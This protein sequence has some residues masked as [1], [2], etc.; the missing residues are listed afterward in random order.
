MD[1]TE[2]IEFIKKN[3]DKD[4][5]LINELGIKTAGRPKN[6]KNVKPDYVEVEASKIADIP[7]SESVLKKLEDKPKR[8]PTEAQIAGLQKGREALMAKWERLRIEREAIK[9]GEGQNIRIKSLVKDANPHAKTVL[10]K[11]KTKADKKYT[12]VKPEPP[13]T[14]RVQKEESEDEFSEEEEPEE[15]T[16]DFPTETEESEVDSRAPPKIKKLQ[17]KVKALKKVEEQLTKAT[18]NPINVSNPYNKFLKW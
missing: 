13:K 14:K 12:K 10:L 2:L 16:T 3:L 6:S 18:P 7:I 4:K 15:E 5:N 8:Q 1:R 9:S 11:V 17:R